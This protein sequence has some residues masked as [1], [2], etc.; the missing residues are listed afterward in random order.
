MKL[1]NKNGIYKITI[2][3]QFNN[4]VSHFISRCR[5]KIGLNFICKFRIT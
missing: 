1:R 2:N 3:D 5:L 4:N